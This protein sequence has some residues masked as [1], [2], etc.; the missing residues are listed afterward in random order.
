M[1]LDEDNMVTFKVYSSLN[2]T[3]EFFFIVIKERST[4]METQ[5]DHDKGALETKL[6][7][8]QLKPLQGPRT[9]N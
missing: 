3:N 6:D 4:K 2:T 5:K 7:A 1:Q 9:M 8:R